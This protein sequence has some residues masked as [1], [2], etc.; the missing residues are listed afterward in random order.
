MPRGKQL[1]ILSPMEEQE[2]LDHRDALSGERIALHWEGI[3]PRNGGREAW[4]SLIR[5]DPGSKS[6]LHVHPENDEFFV[7][8]EGAGV[9]REEHAGEIDEYSIARWDIILA[10]KGVAKQI[11][12]TGTETMMLVQVYAPPPPAS[13]LEEILENHEIAV[14]L[15]GRS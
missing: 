2:P 6:T 14:H 15:D 8:V 12:N 11:E 3:G 9:V 1:V 4:V 5:L 10:P 7:V 13:T